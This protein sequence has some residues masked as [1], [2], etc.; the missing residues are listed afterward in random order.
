MTTTHT[1]ELKIIE[2][3]RESWPISISQEVVDL[4]NKLRFFS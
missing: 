2:F 3:Y 4:I 1:V